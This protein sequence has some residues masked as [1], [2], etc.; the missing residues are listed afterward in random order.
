MSLDLEHCILDVINL[1]CVTKL[2]INFLSS[3][4][5]MINFLFS[6]LFLLSV[7]LLQEKVN[8]IVKLEMLLYKA[9]KKKKKVFYE[10]L[11]EI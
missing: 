8:L 7:Y 5:H 6:H 2:K 11:S 4:G 10:G 9:K 3:L 1:H